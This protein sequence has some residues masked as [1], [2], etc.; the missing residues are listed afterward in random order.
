V[1]RIHLTAAG[2]AAQRPVT[3]VVDRALAKTLE[4]IGDRDVEKL[5]STLRHMI[6]NARKL[7]G[8]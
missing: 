1:Q 3:E 7:N 6:G 4:G 2:R 8:P 5:K